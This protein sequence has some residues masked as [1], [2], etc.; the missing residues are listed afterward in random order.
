MRSVRNKGG[1]REVRKTRNEVNIALRY[2]KVK[3][4]KK[5]KPTYIIIKESIWIIFKI[6]AKNVMKMAWPKFA[7][8]YV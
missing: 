2:E 7:E 6:V 8:L 1:T 3:L 4:N 5:L